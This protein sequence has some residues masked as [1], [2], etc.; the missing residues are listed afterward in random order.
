MKI[1]NQ[2]FL[3]FL[4]ITILLSS[5]FALATYYISEK[6][7]VNQIYS[8]LESVAQGK[9]LQIEN[10]ISNINE[11]SDFLSKNSEII[12]AI[13]ETEPGSQAEGLRKVS[14]NLSQ[15]VIDI[16]SFK[17]IY[18]LNARGKVVA[19]SN[20]SLMEK[21]YA[22]HRAFVKGQEKP[23]QIIGFFFDEEG[24]YSLMA[25]DQIKNEKQELLAIVVLELHAEDFLELIND[26]TGL[27]RTGETNIGMDMGDKTVYLSPCK[28][29]RNAALKRILPS[30]DL[31]YAMNLA[32]SGSDGLHESVRD[33]QGQPVIAYT[34]LIKDTQWGMVTKIDREEAL[35]G[36]NF[37]QQFLLIASLIFIILVFMISYFLGRYIAKPVEELI[38]LTNK[39]KEGN[40][41]LR[42]TNRYNNELGTLAGSF[43][44]MSDRL[45]KKMEDLDKFAYIISHDL[46][47]PLNSVTGLLT[48]I[49]Q[50]NSKNQ[51][52]Q[53]NQLIEM[54]LAKTSQMRELIHQ[55][56]ASAKEEKQ[57]KE[58]VNVNKLIDQ[59]IDNINPP[60]NISILVQS[61]IPPIRFHK[62]SLIQ[63]FQNLIS[64][65][66][67]YMDKPAG[68]I[69]IENHKE[70]T[71]YVFSIK[72]NGSGINKEDLSKIFE[73]FGKAHTNEKI[74]S[75]GIGLAVVKKLLRKTKERYG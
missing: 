71:H 16:F 19:C 11:M 52:G 70:N 4:L 72:D 48:L 34:R 56:L 13:K 41:G 37:L 50:K 31:S 7:V 29:D 1:R 30:N 74:D 20:P 27:G 65:A 44:E 45:E 43:N 75:S 23:N 33:Y 73:M 67:K 40:L 28:F 24:N 17:K 12:Q 2:I 22:R 26:Y 62:V 36:I 53:E 47:S 51:P 39:I 25:T 38:E 14:D 58:I 55:I 8:H 49:K 69:K 35:A 66:V 6:I 63:V 57:T 68:E 3:C 54:A 15:Y 10:M 64:N 46:K 61:N 9:A 60:E 42:I 5:F 32:I 59:V 21:D 18:I